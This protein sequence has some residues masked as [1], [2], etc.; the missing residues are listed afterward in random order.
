MVQIA[1]FLECSNVPLMLHVLNVRESVI[2]SISEISHCIRKVIPI[3]QPGTGDEEGDCKRSSAR[4]WLTQQA[5]SLSLKQSKSLCCIRKTSA[6]HE[7][8]TCSLHILACQTLVATFPCCWIIHQG[9]KFLLTPLNN[10]HHGSSSV[11]AT[12]IIPHGNVATDR[13]LHGYQELY[14]Q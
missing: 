9:D 5:T 10:L 2:P 6:Q 13:C 7:P 12:Q 1:K 11:S 8:S 3:F 4:L 14:P